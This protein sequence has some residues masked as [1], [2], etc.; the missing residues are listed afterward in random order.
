M[1]AFRSPGGLESARFHLRFEYTWDSS[2]T[3]AD[4]RGAS[5]GVA[6]DNLVVNGVT[7]ADTSV[8]LQLAVSIRRIRYWRA[9]ASRTTRLSRIPVARRKFVASDLAVTYPLP[10]G[11]AILSA[12]PHLRA[13]SCTTPAVDDNRDDQLRYRIRPCRS[14]LLPLRSRSLPKYRPAQAMAQY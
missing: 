14:F 4:V 10:S 8:D 5:C 7:F 3:C 6:I 11:D 12:R 1:D 2:G 13:R 9:T